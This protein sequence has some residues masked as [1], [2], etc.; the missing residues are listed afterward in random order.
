MKRPLQPVSIR[1][2]NLEFL[3]TNSRRTGWRDLYRTILSLSWPRFALSVLAVYL[4]INVIFALTEP[5][6]GLPTS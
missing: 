3:R 2:G 4:V 1:S 5:V 6:P